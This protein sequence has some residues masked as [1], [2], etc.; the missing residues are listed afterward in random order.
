MLTSTNL[1]PNIELTATPRQV[2]LLN[3][4]LPREFRFE[5]LS[6]LR[7]RKNKRS[8][9]RQYSEPSY[10]RYYTR[11][12][13]SQDLTYKSEPLIRC[14][15]VFNQLKQHPY[16]KYFY[17]PNTSTSN[18]LSA[19]E[20]NLQKGK[21]EAASEF[22]GEVRRVWNSYWANNEPGSEVYIAT[23]TIAS[24]FESLMKEVDA[25][26]LTIENSD[27]IQKLQ[28]QVRKVSGTLRKLT[29]STLNPSF[30][31]PKQMSERERA[32]LAQ[33]IK[34]LNQQQLVAMLQ[35]I[36]DEVNFSNADKGIELDLRALSSKACR[37]LEKYVKR[38]LAPHKNRRPKF[39]FTTKSL[40]S[41]L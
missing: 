21:Y 38:V 40:E 26:E 36:K 2:A 41:T 24:F 5:A 31:T 33:Q 14:K 27:K 7:K 39:D 12:R 25:M 22:L 37:E 17:N 35:V 23:T 19:I 13:H 11:E 28:K 4:I 34:K 1:S 8:T 6:E 16:A 18:T 32:M 20:Q 15:D 3:N 29:D 30:D 9:H 10:K